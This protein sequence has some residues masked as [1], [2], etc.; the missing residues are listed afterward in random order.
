ML[1]TVSEWWFWISVFVI[2]PAIMVMACI[3]VARIL[4]SDWI[5]A[6]RVYCT[7]RRNR[8][9]I[10][11][12]FVGGDHDGG[13]KGSFGSNTRLTVYEGG[14]GLSMI[15]PPFVLPPIFFPW[16]AVSPPEAVGNGCLGWLQKHLGPKDDLLLL[17]ASGSKLCFLC[18]KEDWEEQ[19]SAMY[20]DMA[21]GTEKGIS[22][23]A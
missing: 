19:I 4:R 7:R 15:W 1:A 21:G 18:R 16:H 22:R 13:N 6:A 9:R 20:M 17:R 14:I 12:R 8:G 23:S 10:L 11:G 2:A 3:K 5:E